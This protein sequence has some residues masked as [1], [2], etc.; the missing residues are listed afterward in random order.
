NRALV[1][2]AIARVIADFRA[3]HAD[4]RRDGEAADTDIAPVAT[5][6]VLDGE[7]TL[8]A[9]AAVR[10]PGAAG[11]IDARTPVL[12]RSKRL[13]ARLIGAFERMSG[14]AALA[15][16]AESP[17]TERDVQSLLDAQGRIV[18]WLS[19]KRERP[20]MDTIV[21][22]LPLLAAVAACLIGFAA[23]A[24]RQIGR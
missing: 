24:I 5:E 13:D 8:V 16:A 17:N 20:A 23:M 22:L 18:G 11:A 12:V 2:A 10:I 3:G 7:V 9:V 21:R 14:G 1:P 4:Q 6:I 15:F 19:W